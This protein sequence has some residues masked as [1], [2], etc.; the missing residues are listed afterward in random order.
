MSKVD[1]IV[2][3][4]M[5]LPLD[6]AADCDLTFTDPPWEQGLVKMFETLAQRDAGL[7]KPGNTIDAILH[8]MFELAPKAPCVVEYSVKGHTRVL[9]AGHAGGHLDGR[10]CHATQTNGKPYVFI[11]FNSGMPLPRNPKGWEMIDHV[12]EYHKPTKVFE[13]FAGH[14]QHTRRFVEHG[15]DVIASELSPHRAQKLMDYFNL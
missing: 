2:S 6:R 5:D 11:I 15:A 10:V 9:E 14:G 12:F 4:I 1:F 8:R 7:P 3:D 13:P